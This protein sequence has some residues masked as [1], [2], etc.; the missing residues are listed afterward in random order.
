[1]IGCSMRY[2]RAPLRRLITA[3]L[4]VFLLTSGREALADLFRPTTAGE[5]RV[6]QA[7]ASTRTP[8]GFPARE[9]LVR[10]DPSVLARHL[11]PSGA[12]LATGRAERARQLD[13]ILRIRLFP[14][15]AVTIRR[16]DVEAL[17][18]GGIAWTGDAAGHAFSSATLVITNQQITGL[19]QFE[20]RLFTIEPVSRLI[21]RI[22]EID[23][24]RFPPEHPTQP[25]EPSSNKSGNLAPRQE[26]RQ[27]EATGTTRIR[28]L[29][30]HTP[31]A[32]AQ[33]P[34]IINDIN[35]AVALSNQALKR[36][37]TNIKL[38]LT[39]AIRVNY[40]EGADFNANLNALTKGREFARLRR[41]RDNTRSDLVVLLRTAGQYCGIG[42]YIENPSPASRDY[43]FSATA[44]ACITNHT[45]AHEIGH[46]MGL[47]HDRYVHDVAPNS[48]YNFGYVN[49][50]A[51]VRS[52]MAYTDECTANG[53]SCPKVN[54]F[55]SPA[56]CTADGRPYGCAVRTKIGVRKGRP[57][58]ADAARRLSETGP[59]IGSYRDVESAEAPIP[60]AD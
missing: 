8:M 28:V 60:M 30:A 2:D 56:P 57:G 26:D 13:G 24:A 18:T 59:G 20:D 31:A 40:N 36:G 54:F 52:I 46:N 4:M 16:T 35:L 49:L 43:G 48:V 47:K 38:V 53:I 55:S 7:E 11:A 58:A 33:S 29:V 10:L 12:D 17:E 27:S 3:T 50:K 14:D 32:D 45:F 41:T 34:N 6:A 23:S 44:R 15:V 22:V 1:M 25:P 51:R 9:R 19:V 39:R 5:A 37:S 21:H 42:W